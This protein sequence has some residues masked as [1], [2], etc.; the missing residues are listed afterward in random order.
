T[1]TMISPLLAL[2]MG[3]VKSTLKPFRPTSTPSIGRMLVP[4][5]TI[6]CF[7]GE[8]EA[9]PFTDIRYQI[10]YWGDPV[11]VSDCPGVEI[12]SCNIHSFP[13]SAYTLSVIQPPFALLK[14]SVSHGKGTAFTF[15]IP[16]NTENNRKYGSVGSDVYAPLCALFTYQTCEPT[17]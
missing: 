12:A 16:G 7:R 11:W 6:N 5:S 10:L 3:R 9:P 8:K 2:T 14:F 15:G 17:S 1:G 13:G 4:P